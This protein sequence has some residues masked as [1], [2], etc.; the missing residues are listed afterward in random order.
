MKK[1][2]STIQLELIIFPRES[3]ICRGFEFI[4]K[5]EREDLKGHKE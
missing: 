4:R 2:F 5:N 1:R 3:S